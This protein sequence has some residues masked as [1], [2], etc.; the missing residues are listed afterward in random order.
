MRLVTLAILANA[1]L[2]EPLLAAVFP[3]RCVECRSWLARPTR[4]PLCEACWLALPRHA[5][6]LCRCG[7]VLPPGLAGPCGRCR[8][9]LTEFEAGASIGPYE[10]GL[11]TLVHELKFRGRRRVASRLAEVC[12]EIPAVSALLASRP[13]VVPVPLHGRRL[14]ERGYNQSA[15]IAGALA[16]R[17][18]LSCVS[19]ALERR[20]WTPPQT[21]LSAAAR[22]ANVAGAFVVRQPAAVAGRT[23]ILVD[24]VYTTGATIR[25][26]AR[27]L[28]DANAREVRVLTIARVT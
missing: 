13:I 21:G 18:G 2:V 9:G 25:A 4:G 16:R 22:R 8:R 3:A 12:L 23:V 1:G 5:S 24:D 20:R 28:R 19:G 6:P 7:H 26:C 10:G 17:A 14:R 11:R 15:L 27:A